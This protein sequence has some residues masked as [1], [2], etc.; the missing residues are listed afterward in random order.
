MIEP[1]IHTF[2]IPTLATR[3]FFVEAISKLIIKRGIWT[4]NTA[5][6]SSFRYISIWWWSL[7]P[8]EHD[9][10]VFG[11]WPPPLC[12]ERLVNFSPSDRNPASSRV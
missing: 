12:R 11:T 7:P 2:I 5:R 1:G 8:P 6:S 3:L 4:P 9:D 10:V